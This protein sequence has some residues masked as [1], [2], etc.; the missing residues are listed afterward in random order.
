MAFKMRSFL[1][2]ESGWIG[3]NKLYHLSNI[4]DLG[5]CQNPLFTVGEQS[6]HGYDPGSRFGKPSRF[7]LV[8]LQ[9]LSRAQLVPTEVIVSLYLCQGLNY[10]YFHII[11]DGHQ[12]NSRGLYT[13][14][15]DSY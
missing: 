9:C 3:I 6:I 14:Y 5:G 2:V 11:G 12:P 1:L 8:F 10:H 13:H 7:P 15:K 4:L